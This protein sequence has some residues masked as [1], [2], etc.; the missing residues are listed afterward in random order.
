[1]SSTTSDSSVPSRSDRSS[2]ARRRS[3]KWRWLASPVKGSVRASDSSR[4]RTSRSRTWRRP[5]RPIAR[6][7]A[8]R[9]T[10]EALVE[11]CRAAALA[12]DGRR[13]LVAEPVGR[14]LDADED[15]VVARI[16]RRARGARV[17]RGEALAGH[18]QEH[19]QLAAE[20]VDARA[21]R[22]LHGLDAAHRRHA[23]ELQGDAQPLRAVQRGDDVA[24]R[25][26]PVVPGE[27]LLEP[28]VRARGQ[29]H[30]RPRRVAPALAAGERLGRAARR[31]GDGDDGRDRADGD[32]ELRAG[33]G[34]PGRRACAARLRDRQRAC[35][36]YRGS[37][38]DD[39]RSIPASRDESAR[40]AAVPIPTRPRPPEARP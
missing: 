18:G 21:A 3:W 29:G 2:S 26:V 30:E 13:E 38:G 37:P 32:D 19:A 20:G 33:D 6:N 15:G 39:G 35:D 4:W 31:P 8:I 9:L 40:P 24:L 28:D 22:R 23:A 27:D 34:A 10:T 1:M 16:D 7:S 36:L 17:G 25:V 12:T 11:A 5:M 14:R